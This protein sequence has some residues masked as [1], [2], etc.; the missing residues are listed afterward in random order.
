MQTSRSALKIKE[1]I[2]LTQW[3]GKI[4]M[5]CINKM[6]SCSPKIFNLAQAYYFIASSQQTILTIFQQVCV[7]NQ[8]HRNH[9]RKESFQFVLPALPQNLN[10]MLTLMLLD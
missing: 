4:C 8:H 1:I 6:C 2:H 9:T 5:E 7:H 10:G 3:N